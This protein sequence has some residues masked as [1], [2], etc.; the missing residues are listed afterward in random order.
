MSIPAGSLLGPYEILGIIGAGGMGEVYRAKDSR[1]DRL[2]AVK[3]L[4][5]HLAS[6]PDALGRFQREAKAIA[7]LN[8]PNIVGIFDFGRMHDV[9][10]VVMELLE[11]QSLREQLNAGP[12]PPR[13]AT[14]L[15]VQM[16]RGLAAAHA[17]GVIHRDLKPDNLWV[18]QTGQLKILDFGLAKNLPDPVPGGAGLL[19][20]EAMSLGPR[21]EQGMIMGT[22]GYM[23]PEQVRGEAVDRRSDLFS[24]GAV[25]FEMLTARKAFSRATAAD[26]LSAILKEDPPELAESS[27]PLSPGL[28]RILDR[29]V[30]KVPDHRFQNAE[31]LAFALENLTVLSDS[32]AP[33]PALVPLR[34]KVKLVRWAGALA[35]V[36]LLASALGWLA[37]G[38]GQPRP[39]VLR[40]E[41]QCPPDLTRVDRP[42]I[43]PDGNYL[44]FRATDK[45]GKNR[46]WVRPL[47]AFEARPLPGTEGASRPFWSP[48]SRFLAFVAGGSL[49]RIE[50][51]GGPAQKV[52]DAPSAADGSWGTQGVI[53]FDGNNDDPIRSV[54]A[55]GGAPSVAVPLDPKGKEFYGWP[56]FLPDGRHF[57]FLA[58]G[59]KPEDGVLRLGALGSKATQA[60]GPAQS[61]VAYAPPG[62]LLFVR[63]KTLLVQAFDPRALKFK[64]EAVAI[65][66]HV[67]IDAGGLAHFSVSGNGTLVYRTGEVGNR[68]LWVDRAGQEEGSVGDLG[69][70]SDPALSPG[71]DRLAYD[72]ADSHTGKSSIWIRDLRRE[73]SSRFSF[74][75]D[76]ACPLWSPDGHRLVFTQGLDLYE[77]DLEGQGQD[78]LLFAS[79]DKKYACDWSRDGRYLAYMV[80]GKDTGW[81][82]WILPTF[83]DRK[84]YPF[85]QAAYTE[86]LPT[87]SP[88]GK[89]LAYQSNE[90]GRSE[91]YVQNFPGPGGKV[92]ISAAGGT[93]PHWRD[94]GKE[95]YYRSLDEKIMAV[96]MQSGPTLVASAPRA[97]FQAWFDASDGRGKYLPNGNAPRFLTLAPL[98]RGSMA[99]MAVVANWQAEL[100]R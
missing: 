19:A 91:V 26:T 13:K 59:E 72:L 97:L 7:A 2:V 54:P 65:A 46:I 67:A 71:G 28:R 11:G 8:H 23:S 85:L 76:S 86:A 77:R 74:A 68:F 18:T 12:L 51:N 1:L 21:T 31:D 96:S 69:A 73:V 37:H 70:Y 45:E 100:E 61:L 89:H 49:K 75:P 27:L 43:S 48:D 92:Q 33:S 98:S 40:F 55:E 15:A 20:T 16:A 99:P 63:D 84:A 25:L 53:L 3:V 82:I 5:T 80:R 4:P 22:M 29:C 87:F 64:G 58:Q 42:R 52:C 78:H 57:L 32:R 60:L 47:N 44:A 83:G 17:K 36:F 66:E 35:G 94:D 56:E 14:E 81:D 90:S 6:D 50:V 30:E 34:P 95:L 39:R 93:E 88:D 62:Y 79:A 9:A 24:F 41:I 10:F 38:S